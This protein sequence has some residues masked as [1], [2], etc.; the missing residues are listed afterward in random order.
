MHPEHNRKTLEI[1]RDNIRVFPQGN[2]VVHHMFGESVVDL[3]KQNYSD[4]YVTAH[5]EVPGEMFEIAMQKSLTDDGVV[6]STSNI[7]E[8]ISRKVQ[9]AADSNQADEPRRLRFILGTEAGMV[10]SIVR[11][12]Q[13]ILE[14]TGNSKIEAEI[15]FPV[16]QE[17]F[18]AT[19]GELDLSIVPGV[20]G[21]EGCSTAG[22]CATCPFMKMN[23]LDALTDVLEMVR[24]RNEATKLAAH[25]PPNR[26]EG[27]RIEGRPAVDWG[28]DPIV[29]MRQFM[30]D[31]T[32]PIELC[33]KVMNGH[34][35]RSL[36]DRA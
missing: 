12:V 29:Y 7:L 21:G 24:S 23:D 34:L 3:V 32:I 27:K 36:L 26:L 31:K 6:G 22:G 8:F 9:E 19:D 35:N 14:S 17:A 18:T 30:Q 5:L 13:G 25:L 33:Q 4:C 2:C 10:T 28:T 20:S 1:L 16:A 15:V 11:S